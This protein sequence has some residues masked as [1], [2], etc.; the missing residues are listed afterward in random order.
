MGALHVGDSVNSTPTRYSHRPM[1]RERERKLSHWLMSLDTVTPLGVNDFASCTNTTVEWRT[2]DFEGFA[3]I[4]L[5]SR[6]LFVIF[7]MSNVVVKLSA[8]IYITFIRRPCAHTRRTISAQIIQIYPRWSSDNLYPVGIASLWPIYKKGLGN[9][10]CGRQPK[11][12]MQYT[13]H[14]LT[15]QAE[16]ESWNAV[17]TSPVHKLQAELENRKVAIAI[18]QDEDQSRACTQLN[19][20][21]EK[22]R[23]LRSCCNT[24]LPP[25]SLCDSGSR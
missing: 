4:G 8:Y 15:L 10:Q 18:V 7:L 21:R 3:R 20:H 5:K 17:Y 13:Q 24:Q 1:R 22:I 16:L 19:K 25:I 9:T 6:F 23:C 14:Q 12:G 11:A 2:K